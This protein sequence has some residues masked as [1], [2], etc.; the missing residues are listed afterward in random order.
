MT[1]PT[2]DRLMKPEPT[3]PPAPLVFLEGNAV[4]FV[5]SADES[6]IVRDYGRIRGA[7]VQVRHADPAAQRRVFVPVTG[8]VKAYVFA[9]GDRRDLEPALLAAQLERSQPV[10]GRAA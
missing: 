9:E 6:W 7:M 3:P 5:D 1:R 10:A 2:E 4:L 8:S